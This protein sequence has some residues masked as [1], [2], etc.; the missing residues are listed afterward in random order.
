M[1][2]LIGGLI[3]N[4]QAL[5][6]HS[7]AL[8]VTGRNLANVNNPG[9]ARQRVVTEAI[10]GP[11]GMTYEQ[12]VVQQ[13]RDSILDR[14]IVSEAGDG[15]RLEALK[16]LY[17]R[18]N[19]IL[20]EGIDGSMGASLDSAT[21][22]SSGLSGDLSSFFNAW[23]SLSTAPN[24]PV[25]KQETFGR[26]QNLADRLNNAAQDLDKIATDNARLLDGEVKQ[27][28]A[29]LE[30]LASLNDQI[31]R[32]ESR[33]GNVAN[34]LRDL[35]QQAL[36]ELGQILD[37]RYEQQPDGRVMIM[38]GAP[39]AEA[40]LLDAQGPSRIAATDD[41][42]M[43]S[44][45]GVSEVFMPE[46][47]SLSV[48]AAG[49]TAGS[50][51]QA[52]RGQLDSLS[53]QLIDSVNSVYNPDG[54]G[55]DFFAG[56]SAATITVALESASTIDGR[57]GVAYSIASLADSRF[58]VQNGDQLDGAISDFAIS[59]ATEKASALADV[60]EK[61]EHQTLVKNLILGQRAEVS[62]VSMDEELSNMMRFQNAFQASARVV[63]ALN[64]ML[65]L[66]TTRLGV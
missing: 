5:S 64:S 9:Y 42:L 15:G 14:N 25:L 12:T 29:L 1:S 40:T 58:A 6:V 24:D 48:L 43:A 41:G 4:T 17:E 27:A 18:L 22:T 65:E 36:E 13:L 45:E 3:N 46:K 10:A 28:N 55:S 51:I 34:E 33:K 39:G 7:K 11:G 60:I 61:Q 63:N 2:G 35:R 52:F 21:G 23:E 8:Q 47:G 19:A 50:E 54:A 20:G 26:A 49:G 30:K 57:N 32:V 56:N 31:V 66:V 44:R 62:G 53:V 59:L 38:S 37:L 16:A